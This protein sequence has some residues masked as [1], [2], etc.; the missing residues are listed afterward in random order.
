MATPVVTGERAPSATTTATTAAT[1]RTATQQRLRQL[2]GTA[3]ARL[4]A[5]G[6]VLTTLVLLFG[7]LTAWQVSVRA[8][9]AG[10]VVTHSQPLSQDAAEI[11]RSLADADTT[12]ASA[13]LLAGDA[14][15]ALRERYE[16]DLATA[17][18]LLA[19][20]AARTDASS[21]AQRWVAE[22]NQQLPKYAGLVETARANDRQGL[23]LGGAYLRYAS[24]QMQGTMLPAA[25]K[26]AEAENQQLDR[27]YAAAESFPWTALVL[28]L[29][30]LGMLAWCQVLLLRRTNRV[31]NIGMLGASAAVLAGL[32]WLTVGTVSAGL[33]LGDSRAQGAVPL[34]V[35]N[36]ARIE[37]LQSRAAENLD[38]VAR[39][40]S[41]SYDKDWLKYT[42]ALAGAPVADGRT[43]AGQGT[44]AQAAA[45]APKD[46]AAALEQAG[47]LFPSWDARHRAAEEGDD[48]AAA[49]K[50]VVGPGGTDTSEAVFSALDGQL[51]KAAAAELAAFERSADGVGGG[52]TALAVGAAVLALLAAAGVAVGLGRRL[53]E[54][55]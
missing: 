14:P 12:A 20:A 15:P 35:L 31:F 51:G 53:A 11:Y 16:G 52:L 47:K 25:Q 34:R 27:D 37:A 54:Y 23:P 1:V 55:R 46:A 45:G 19:Q 29:L 9:A 38:L 7:A 32:L 48:Y 43:R 21:D 26:L 18:R 13:F 17:A 44:L 5:A 40:G 28:G 3:P 22:L 42:G 6:V 24:K 30:T 49:V 4:R 10:Q 39:G 41:D 8:K 2:T 33:D 50:A 36:Q